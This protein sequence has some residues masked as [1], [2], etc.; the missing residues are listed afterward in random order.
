V[1]AVGQAPV[2]G[3]QTENQLIIQGI[4]VSGGSVKPD[5]TG[6]TEHF[7]VAKAVNQVDQINDPHPGD[8]VVPDWAAFCLSRSA[9][10][11][12][13]PARSSVPNPD[14]LDAAFAVF[15]PP[16]PEGT[17]GP[18]DWTAHRRHP[19]S[20]PFCLP[21]A[22]P[23]PDCWHAPTQLLTYLGVTRPGFGQSPD[24]HSLFEA[25][26]SHRHSSLSVL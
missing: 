17:Q 14:G 7:D 19:R 8:L 26:Y 1:Q 25:C 11:P 4:G 20:T 12:T 13:P 2:A 21:P 5:L 9:P 18:S 24:F 22:S 15:P 3:T 6:I 16:Q 23:L 10:C